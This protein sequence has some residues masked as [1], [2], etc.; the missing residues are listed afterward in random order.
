MLDTRPNAENPLNRLAIGTILALAVVTFACNGDSTTTPA[1]SPSTTMTAE[2]TPAATTA[3]PTATAEPTETATATAS[4]NPTG[5][6]TAEPT[7]TPTPT[8]TV[9]GPIETLEPDPDAEAYADALVFDAAAMGEGWTLESRDDFSDSLTE[10]F[11]YDTE[12]C[13]TVTNTLGQADDISVASRLGQAAADY[14]GPI[15]DDQTATIE[16]EINVLDDEDAA[17]NAAALLGQVAESDLLIQCFEDVFAVEVPDV[18]VTVERLESSTGLPGPGGSGAFR[19]VLTDGEDEL[20]FTS[21]FYIWQ[22]GASWISLEFS[23][24]E[25]SPD[26]VRAAMD[27]LQ[28]RLDANPAP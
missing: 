10:G 8:G 11:E 20:A 17:T 6:A 22:A 19:V 26:T 23:G 14:N 18:D 4:E 27:A 16:L 28:E 15:G 12:A 5:T 9:P 25:L 7:E 2:P 24:D 21:E 13:N 3:T 1:P